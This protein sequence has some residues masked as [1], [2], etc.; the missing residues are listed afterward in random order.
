VDCGL[1]LGKGKGLF[2]KMARII[3]FELF[4]NRK[5]SELDSTTH[6]PMEAL[7]HDEPR[8]EGGVSGSSKL[9]LSANSV[10]GGPM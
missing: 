1:I 3:G 2:A 4:A 7:A 10:H 6:R 5:S 8:T 9:L